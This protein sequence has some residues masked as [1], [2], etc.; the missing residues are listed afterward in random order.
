VSEKAQSYRDP[1]AFIAEQLGT[2]KTE[3]AAAGETL[4][5]KFRSIERHTEQ[6]REHGLDIARVMFTDPI[7]QAAWLT[8]TRHDMGPPLMRHEEE[9]TLRVVGE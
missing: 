4:A 8:H 5:E 2:A 7:V 3:A 6:M 1:I 9:I